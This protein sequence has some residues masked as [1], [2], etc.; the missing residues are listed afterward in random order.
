MLQV[1]LAS[2]LH[3]LHEEP[4]LAGHERQVVLAVAATV[5]EYVPAPHTT[6]VAA[7]VVENVPA[8]QLVQAREPVVDLKVPATQ[9]VQTPP[10]GPVYPTLQVQEV[11]AGLEMGELEFVEQFKQVIRFD[12]PI[13]AEYVVI[14]HAKQTVAI[15]APTTV[16]YVPAAQVVQAT[17]PVVALKVPGIQATHGSPL[18]PVYPTLQAQLVGWVQLPRHDSP[19]FA[20]QAVQGPP[21]GP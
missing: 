5:V 21:T 8:T 14:G 15:V 10:L 18:G 9:A 19:E 2:A 6:Q 12:A 16:E 3:P 4:E 13:V 1:Q 17:E 7:A 20:G 11:I